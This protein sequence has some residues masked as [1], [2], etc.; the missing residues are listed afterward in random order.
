MDKVLSWRVDLKSHILFPHPLVCAT[1]AET[2]DLAVV[3]LG[4]YMCADY[5]C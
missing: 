4:V 1:L 2:P 5:L 3:V